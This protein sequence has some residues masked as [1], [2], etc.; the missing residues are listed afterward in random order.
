MAS[1]DSGTVRPTKRKRVFLAAA[2]LLLVCVLA[3]GAVSAEKTI[4]VNTES[5]FKKALEWSLSE[6]TTIVMMVDITLDHF[7]YP[8]QDH[9]LTLTT[10]KDTN[11]TISWI[12]GNSVYP[13]FGMFYVKSGKHLTI[14]GN[15]TGTLTLK[16]KSDGQQNLIMI[17]D[18]GYFTLDTGGILANNTADH[19]GAVN[20][21]G[22]IFTMSGGTIANNTAYEQGGAG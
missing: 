12:S 17:E 5:D 9:N 3:A 1:R 20:M 15:G 13:E 18:T 7:A 10:G 11:H 21:T 6:D 16:G 22:G 14:T 2:V 4:C 19:G 8:L